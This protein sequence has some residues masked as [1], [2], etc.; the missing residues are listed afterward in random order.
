MTCSRSRLRPIASCLSID[1]IGL[2]PGLALLPD[3][4]SLKLPVD[5]SASIAVDETSK[6]IPCQRPLSGR[7]SVCVPSTRPR[8]FLGHST[9]IIPNEGSSVFRALIP[10]GI[11][12]VRKQQK[13]STANKN[14]SGAHGGLCFSSSQHP[15]T[16][17]GNIQSSS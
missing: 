10:R 11:R 14:A 3:Y 5:H 15:L 12:P 16:H 17:S 4:R 7:I 9:Q 8:Y 13:E 6:S 1:E 2:Q